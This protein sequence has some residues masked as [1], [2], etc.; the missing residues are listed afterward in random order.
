MD[1]LAGKICPKTH[2][3]PLRSNTQRAFFEISMPRKKTDV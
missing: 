3:G 1:T 2:E